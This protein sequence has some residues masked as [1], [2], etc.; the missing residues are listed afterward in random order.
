M[1]LEQE[2]VHRLATIRLIMPVPGM[3]Q[4]FVDLLFGSSDIEDQVVAHAD[5]LELWPQ[6]SVPVLVWGN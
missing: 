3:S 5:R 4:V 2:D 1:M 6:F